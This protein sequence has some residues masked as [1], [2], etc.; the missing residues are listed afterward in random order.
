MNL[1]KAISDNMTRAKVFQV[2][3]ANEAQLRSELKHL[4][5]TLD[6]ARVDVLLVLPWDMSAVQVQHV[7]CKENLDRITISIQLFAG[8]RFQM[9]FHRQ[10]Q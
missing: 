9:H 10:R 3:V 4:H 1:A 8:T 6:D 5:K 7:I 2:T